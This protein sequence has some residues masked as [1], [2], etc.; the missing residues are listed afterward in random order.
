VNGHFQK[1]FN[2]PSLSHPQLRYA[3]D[4]TKLACKPVK[5]DYSVLGFIPAI[6]ADIVLLLIILAGLLTLRRRGG[7][8]LASLLWKQVRWRFS[9]AEV[10]L[11]R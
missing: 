9:L 7:G 10:L 11:I 5:A 2:V 8:T 4:P 6:I 3:W 1:K